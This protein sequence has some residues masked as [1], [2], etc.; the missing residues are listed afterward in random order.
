[1]E[2]YDFSDVPSIERIKEMNQQVANSEPDNVLSFIT[3]QRVYSEIDGAYA[4]LLQDHHLSESR[5]LILMFLRRAGDNGLSP[6]LIAQ[7][8]SSTKATA[9]KL[10]RGMVADG[11]IVKLASE[12][13]QRSSI[14]RI[15]DHGD[16]LLDHFLPAN[17][18]FVNRLF[19]RLTNDEQFQF[20]YLL[21][22]LLVNRENENNGN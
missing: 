5:F 19:S 13:D 1:M 6:S 10:I 14:I 7:K 2:P 11:M 3:F 20:S 4:D 22:K 8:L 21:Q 17:F 12:I 9:S 15:T 16:E 18:D